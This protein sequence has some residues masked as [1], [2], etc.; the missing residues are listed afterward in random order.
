M[1][2]LKERE[3]MGSELDDLDNLYTMGRLLGRIHALGAVE[4]YQ[5]QALYIIPQ[6]FGHDSVA[7]VSEALY[8]SVFKSRIRQ[9]NH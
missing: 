6:T 9:P 4:P 8:S 1:L 3:G 2:C 5:L 7:F